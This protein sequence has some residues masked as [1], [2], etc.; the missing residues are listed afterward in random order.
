MPDFETDTLPVI[1][2]EELKQGAEGSR[3]V[4]IQR[5][6]PGKHPHRRKEPVYPEYMVTVDVGY[7]Y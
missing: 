4:D 1:R 5:L 6:R 3:S 2:E 7:E